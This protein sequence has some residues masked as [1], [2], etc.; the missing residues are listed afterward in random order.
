MLMTDP[1]LFGEAAAEFPKPYVK[2]SVEPA[3]AHEV[4]AAIARA[5]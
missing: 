4:P 5:Y 2:W 1:F 3:R